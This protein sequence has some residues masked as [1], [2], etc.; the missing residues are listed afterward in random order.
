MATFKLSNVDRFQKLD[1]TVTETSGSPKELGRFEVSPNDSFTYLAG[2]GDF[3]LRFVE[4]DKEDGQ[5]F[6]PTENVISVP[7]AGYAGEFLPAGN[8]VIVQ[9][10]VASGSVDAKVR[11]FKKGVI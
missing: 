4:C 5:Q 2:G 11:M 9:A 8:L 10:Y 7:S 6:I 3:T 1:A